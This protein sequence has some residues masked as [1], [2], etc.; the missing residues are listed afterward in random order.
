MRRVALECAQPSFIGCWNLDDARL[1]QAIIEH[2]ELHPARHVSGRSTYG[3]DPSGKNSVDYTIHPKELTLPSHAVLDGYMQRLHACYRDYLLQWPFLNH[4]IR[5]IDI[6]E[7]NI[8][9]YNPGGHFARV[10]S[11]RTS[12]DNAHRLLAWMTYLNDVEDGGQTRFEHYGIDIKPEQGKTLIWPAEW[13]HAHAGKVVNS[14]V[15]Y[16]ITGWM[17]FPV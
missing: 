16:I 5:D 3:V 7:F 13:T 1:C 10:H 4:V 8:Q 6:G 9:K 12:L 14:G 15:K 17:H 2:F 11:E